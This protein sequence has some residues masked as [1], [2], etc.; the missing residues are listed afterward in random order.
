M[1]S[2][3]KYP[4]KQ[5]SSSP[6][7]KTG[8]ICRH[9]SPRGKIEKAS[10]GKRSG[11]RSPPLPK[12]SLEILNPPTDSN[13]LGPVPSKSALGQ[14][15]IDMSCI[16]VE[17]LNERTVYTDATIHEFVAQDFKG[18]LTGQ[19]DASNYHEFLEAQ[20]Q[21]AD[22]DSGYHVNVIYASADVDERTGHT[23][24][25]MS[26]EIL[27]RPIG[28][29][30]NAV[31]VWKWRKRFGRWLLY[32]QLGIRGM[33]GILEDGQVEDASRKNLAA[34]KESCCIEGS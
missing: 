25:Y 5:R 10:E 15:L 22:V 30:R 8:A 32:K 6:P 9:P 1:P 33:M 29:R 11:H 2:Q 4:S 28:I 20:R 27:G 24:V 23:V 12:T 26:V 19:T 7:S 3:Q 34:S 17:D 16:C 14:E 21:I 13:S 31:I 18:L